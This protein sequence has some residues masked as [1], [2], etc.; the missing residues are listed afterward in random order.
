MTCSAG[1]FAP[2]Y[3]GDFPDMKIMGRV[4]LGCKE[5]CEFSKPIG[6]VIKPEENAMT[7]ER[8]CSSEGMREYD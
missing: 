7:S 6:T 1:I 3:M 2:I 8:V 5:D 4:C